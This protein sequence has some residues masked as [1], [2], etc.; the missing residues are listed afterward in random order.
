MV[1]V[2]IITTHFVVWGILK[3]LE[4]SRHSYD[5]YHSTFSVSRDLCT[6]RFVRFNKV[7]CKSKFKDVYLPFMFACMFKSHVHVWSLLVYSVDTCC[8]RW[9]PMHFC[10]PACWNEMNF[11]RNY[12]TELK[13]IPDYHLLFFSCLFHLVRSDF[14]LKSFMFWHQQGCTFYLRGFLNRNT[15]D[16]LFDSFKAPKKRVISNILKCF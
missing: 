4:G 10:A 1:A 5:S 15:M 16:L 13:I 7:P 2:I 3:D 14:S 11:W 8:Y 6:V 12:C 9:Q